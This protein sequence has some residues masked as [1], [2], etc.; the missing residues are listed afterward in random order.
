[1]TTPGLA[2]ADRELRSPA[3]ASAIERTVYLR[4]Q[5]QGW[6]VSLDEVLL[7]A[8]GTKSRPS[9]APAKRDLSRVKSRCAC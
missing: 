8:T 7:L 5:A 3:C 1:M 9:N 4:R 2:L 6:I